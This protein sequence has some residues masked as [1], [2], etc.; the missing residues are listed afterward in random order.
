MPGNEFGPS[1][2]AGQHTVDWW[3]ISIFLLNVVI[4][5]GVLLVFN[6]LGLLKLAPVVENWGYWG[7]V[8]TAAIL[9]VALSLLV[10]GVLV[11]FAFGFMATCGMVIVLLP[12]LGYFVMKALLALTPQLVSAP[13]EDGF[14]L[15]VLGTILLL[16]TVPSKRKPPQQPPAVHH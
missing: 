13:N 9:A 1:G 6:V 7:V 2:R 3:Q 5:T 10:L 15:L 16:A 4:K 11:L 14:V 12:F 8:A